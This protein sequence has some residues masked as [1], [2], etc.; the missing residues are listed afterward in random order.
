VWKQ[1][2]SGDPEQISAPLQALLTECAAELLIE[3]YPEASDSAGLE[4]SGDDFGRA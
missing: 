3:F 2:K 4:G 1:A